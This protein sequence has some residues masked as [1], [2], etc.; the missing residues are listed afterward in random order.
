MEVFPELWAWGKPDSREEGLEFGF[1][2]SVR[3][4]VGAGRRDWPG[5]GTEASG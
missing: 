2:L 1:R 3:V 5:R 4:P